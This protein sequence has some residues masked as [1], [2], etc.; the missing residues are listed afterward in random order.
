MK[1]SWR[2]E[3]PQWLLIAAMFGFTFLRWSASP[4]R[5]PVHWNL[6]GQVDRYGGKVEALLLVP[7]IA[8][9][10]YLVLLF[11]PRLDPGQANYAQF[12]GAYNVMRISIL[13]FMAVL[14][15]ALVNQVQDP[16]LLIKLL[17]GGLFMMLGSVM[18]KLRPNWFAGIRTPWTL[19]SKASWTKTHRLGGWMFLVAGLLILL[20]SLVRN[21]VA[22]PI[23]VGALFVATVVPIA[24]SYFVW[25][26]DPDKTPPAGTL[27]A[28][29][30]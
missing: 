25:R 29:E 26:D 3:A 9:V 18:G 10:M 12:A 14:H 8:L 1:T 22:V 30:G 17:M 7:L 24:Y 2:I 28:E 20:T 13:V 5:M 21:E 23:M 16:T 4:E 27:P 15:V 6:A 11:I 19:S